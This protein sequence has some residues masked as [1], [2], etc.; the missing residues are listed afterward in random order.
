MLC[1]SSPLSR[2]RGLDSGCGPASDNS[3]G[4]GPKGKTHNTTR[5]ASRENRVSTKPGAAQTSA[6]TSHH[7]ALLADSLAARA[8]QDAFPAD[9][10]DLVASAQ[11][12]R[13]AAGAW[14]QAARTLRQVTTDT[15]G[16]VTPAAAEAR[17]LAWWT[18][19]LAYADPAWTPTSG[20]SA[21]P[22]APQTLAPRA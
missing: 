21:P 19:R 12:A 8:A 5:S 10:P 3:G 22:R 11:A 17:D 18:G 20:P 1:R 13:H 7:C 4:N 9:S 6:L 2:Q 16:Q 15:R 14:F